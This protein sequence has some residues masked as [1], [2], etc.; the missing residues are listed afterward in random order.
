MKNYFILSLLFIGLTT[1]SCSSDDDNSEEVEIEETLLVYNDVEFGQTFDSEIG[2]FFSTATG[3]TFTP[4][5]ALQNGDVI[6]FS[7]YGSESAFIFFTSPDYINFTELE[8]PNARSTKIMNYETGIT[9]EMFDS[10]DDA[11]DFDDIEVVQDNS[12]IGTLDFPVVVLFETQDGKKGAIKLT[13]INSR[14][15]LTDIKVMK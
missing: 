1:M 3:E 13:A 9:A 10:Y 6:D 14:R 4:E 7:Y 8:I 2:I 5:M 12:A 15:L 11:S